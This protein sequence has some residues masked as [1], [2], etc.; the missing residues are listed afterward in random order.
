MSVQVSRTLL[1][2]SLDHPLGTENHVTDMVA[3][4]VLQQH[5]R[6]ERC[7]FRLLRM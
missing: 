7:T 1:P 4:L 2:N 5:N 3:M 6:E